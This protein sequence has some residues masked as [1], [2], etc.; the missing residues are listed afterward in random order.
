MAGW[1][2]RPI[3]RLIVDLVDLAW[4]NDL[5]SPEQRYAL[6]MA[7]RELR[8]TAAQV[9]AIEQFVGRLKT[10]RERGMDDSYAAAATKQA[11]A[12]LAAV[13]A[14]IAA[15]YLSGSVLGLSAAEITSGLAALGLGLGMAPRIGSLF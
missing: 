12:S 3:S 14:P 13:G 15:V 11:A 4:A 9:A 1:I 6:E 10:I 2:G 7:E 5:V 8:I